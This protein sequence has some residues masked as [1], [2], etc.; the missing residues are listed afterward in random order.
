MAL[1]EL[2]K[3]LAEAKNFAT[4]ATL[5]PDGSPQASVVWLDTDGE[6]LIFNT[7]EGR[8]KS[9]N[10]RRDPRVAIAVH[11]AEQPYQ[12]AMIRGRVVE[13]TADGADD[14]IDKLAK[15]YLGL[16][17]Y[18]YRQSGEQRLIVKIAAEKVGL[19]ES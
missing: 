15:K 5:M 19:M 8:I 17:K 12:Q 13:I 14:H 2:A 18:P 10:M 1:P 4:V 11:N 3:Q 7:A 16:D 6:L 9:R